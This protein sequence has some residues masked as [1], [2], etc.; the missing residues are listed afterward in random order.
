M[1]KMKSIQVSDLWGV[2]DP[3]TIW[4]LLVW[5]YL[6]LLNLL[7]WLNLINWLN[8]LNWAESVKRIKLAIGEMGSASPD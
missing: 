7:N 4:L 6:N 8:W 2:F 1:I 5:R 3:I